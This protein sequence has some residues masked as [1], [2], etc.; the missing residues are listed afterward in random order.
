MEN[1]NLT[2]SDSDQG[3]Q[4]SPF[5]K[6]IGLIVWI[7]LIFL[8]GQ[9]AWASIYENEIRAAIIYAAF[10]GLLL[11]GGIIVYISRRYNNI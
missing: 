9:S 2:K 1:H 5:F 10:S 3:N 6:W 11:L 7:G 8:F 4:K